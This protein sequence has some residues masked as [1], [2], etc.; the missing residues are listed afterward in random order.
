VTIDADLAA[1]RAVA[2]QLRG[3]TRPLDPRRLSALSSSLDHSC[4]GIGRGVDWLRAEAEGRERP[5][6]ELGDPEPYRGLSVEQAA[7]LLAER[8]VAICNGTLL[9][10]D[11][12]GAGRR[13][14]SEVDG[15][16]TAVAASG[17]RTAPLA[18]GVS[19]GRPDADGAGKA[20]SDG[21]RTM[22][23]AALAAEPR[24]GT[25]RRAV[26]DAVA[27][28]ARDVR[29]VGLTDVEIQRATG[30]NPNSAR[31]RRVELVDGGW[32]A[33]S[34]VTREHHGRE[35]TVW[36]LTDKAS[37]LVAGL[38]AASGGPTPR[39]DHP[40][41]EHLPQPLRRL[42]DDSRSLASHTPP[43]RRGG[44][45]VAVT[46]PP[47]PVVAVPS[48]WVQDDRIGPFAFRLLVLLHD[49]ALPEQVEDADLRAWLGYT[50]CAYTSALRSLEAAG[51]LC[52]TIGGH[53]QVAR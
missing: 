18:R 2:R 46:R 10:E 9:P 29:T 48:E 31:P 39:V 7:R 15:F 36:V 53:W 50:P 32:L 4:R 24:S 6:V 34:G 13:I 22:K 20:R 28:V 23:A 41:A 30:L 44:L 33:D 35:H 1:I 37:R 12:E 5:A 3:T 14:D 19:S 49:E 45:A 43:P 52:R 8:A 16:V 51:Y 21:S 27:A 25:N 47:L 11:E 17:R 26:L 42:P 38:P 40:P